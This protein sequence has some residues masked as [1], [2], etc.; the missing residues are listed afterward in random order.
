MALQ[1]NRLVSVN[2]SRIY[3]YNFD[4]IEGRGESMFEEEEEMT[5]L[6]G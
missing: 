2:K 4:S 5:D 3:C 1:S 6:A